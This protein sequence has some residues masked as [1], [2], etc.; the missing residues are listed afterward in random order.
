[1]LK[2]LCMNI[3]KGYGWHNRKPTLHALDLH[4]KQLNP[5]LIFLQEILGVDAEFLVLETWPHYSYGKNAVHVDKHYGNAILSKFPIVFSENHDLSMHRFEHRGLLYSII[6]L[7]N[8]EK[9]HVLCVHLGLFRT[10]RKKQFQRIIHHTEH[11]IPSNA[12]VILAG[13]FNDWS[14][15]ATQPLIHDLGLKEAFLTLHH[16][17]AKTFPAWHPLLRLDR[18]YF[19]HFEVVYAERLIEKSW[20]SLSDHIGLHVGLHKLSGAD[21]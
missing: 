15:A 21:I 5:D 2:I 6:L 18:V 3:H 19:R 17:Y 9:L 14:K 11:H 20:K 1:M 13:D 8:G 4:I 10:G 7:P 16:N 12:P